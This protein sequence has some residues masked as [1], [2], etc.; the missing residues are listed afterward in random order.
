MKNFGL[1][2]GNGLLSLFDQ[3]IED[4]LRP[5]G[6]LAWNVDAMTPNTS[7]SKIFGNPRVLEGVVTRRVL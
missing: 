7:C 3:I 6:F 5:L 2:A 4:R 1:K